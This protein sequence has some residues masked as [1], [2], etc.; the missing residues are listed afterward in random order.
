M[1]PYAGDGH[2]KPWRDPQGKLRTAWG[3]FFDDARN[4]AIVRALLSD[5]MV[6]VQWIFLHESLVRRLL[7]Y[8]EEQGEEP[9]LVA[10]AA[11]VL[12]PP[13]RGLPH[14]DHMHV[15]V[16]C[17]P[18]DIPYGCVDIGPERWVKKHR[19]LRGTRGLAVKEWGR[20]SRRSV[21]PPGLVRM[22]LTPSNWRWQ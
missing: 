22:A 12:A 15:R 9:E 18:A 13:S 14:D 10:H 4:W 16:L 7:T 6:E 8:A 21:L 17:D 20:G 2:S 19:M 5:P 1:I 11:E 3:R